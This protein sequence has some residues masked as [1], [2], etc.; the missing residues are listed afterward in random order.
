METVIAKVYKQTR[1]PHLRKIIEVFTVVIAENELKNFF[2]K[3]FSTYPHY[4]YLRKD[5]ALSAKH[6]GK[7][8]HNL[9]EQELEFFIADKLGEVER[10][11]NREIKGCFQVFSAKLKY[12]KYNHL[13]NTSEYEELERYVNETTKTYY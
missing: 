13:L 7:Q 10:E 8:H 9:T 2:L 11:I 5:T 1:E 12:S 3:S 6:T 4:E